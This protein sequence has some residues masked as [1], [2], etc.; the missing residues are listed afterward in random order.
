MPE[1]SS[2]AHFPT[3]NWSRV[4]RA[5]NAAGPEARAALEGLCRDY[6]YP[7]YAFA[8]RRGL[9]PDDAA[10]LIQGFFAD[11]IDRGDLSAADQ[12]RGRFRA[13][14]VT[15]CSHYLSHRRE[16]DRALKRGGARRHIAIDL[17]DAEGRYGREPAHNLTAE[18]L[19]ER[20]WAL[21]LLENV[22]KRLGSE[23]AEAGKA[24]MFDRLQPALEGDGQPGPYRE[25][26][27][28][29]GMSDGAVKVAVHRLR[30]RFRELLREEVAH[31]VADPAD[32]DAELSELLTALA[33]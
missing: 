18:R 24:E 8:R 25:I 20:R 31:T 13:F 5:G 16:H 1:R 7:L 30:A 2:A 21:A 3:T 6:W 29:L 33:R 32:V 14:L 22:L 26:A 17:L 15:C 19:F 11:L 28:S 10:D 27:A 12:E 23:M 9:S 4:V